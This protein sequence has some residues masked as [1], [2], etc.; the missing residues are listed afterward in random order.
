MEGQNFFLDSLFFTLILSFENSIIEF[1]Q[2]HKIQ[3]L[4]ILSIPKSTRFKGKLEHFSDKE[5]KVLI[6]LQF[7][8]N[9]ASLQ[10]PS[11]S[12]TSFILL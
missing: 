6:V 2:L 4:W 3:M 10:G 5:N 9:M 11:L 7:I 1:C 12:L 8:G